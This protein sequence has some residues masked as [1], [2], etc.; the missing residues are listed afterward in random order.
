[1]LQC[2]RCFKYVLCHVYAFVLC[3]RFSR[4]KSTFAT[5]TLLRVKKH[6]R[7]ELFARPPAAQQEPTTPVGATNSVHVLVHFVILFVV[8]S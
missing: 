1:M 3:F 6:T 4:P 5:D 7:C 8:L 2:Y